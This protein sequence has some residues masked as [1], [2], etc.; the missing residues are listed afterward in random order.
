LA[1]CASPLRLGFLGYGSFSM[2]NCCT[3]RG[4]NGSSADV[5]PPAATIVRRQPAIIVSRCL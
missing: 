5:I 1:A 2:R 3:N 4:N